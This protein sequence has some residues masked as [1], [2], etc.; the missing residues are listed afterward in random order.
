MGTTNEFID[1]HVNSYNKLKDSIFGI[2]ENALNAIKDLNFYS[3]KDEGL[4]SK[5]YELEVVREDEDDI[6]I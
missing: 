2:N 4:K 1:T 5:L 6:A 3:E